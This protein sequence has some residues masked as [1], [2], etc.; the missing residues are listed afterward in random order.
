ML[1]VSLDCPFI[2]APSVISNL[3]SYYY[4]LCIK[5]HVTMETDYN[6]LLLKV[7]L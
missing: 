1:P 4:M 3:W 2:I 5:Y 7:V 6:N